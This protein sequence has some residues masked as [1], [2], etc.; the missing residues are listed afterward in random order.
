MGTVISKTI[1]YWGISSILAGLIIA[2]PMIVESRNVPKTI[3]H[4]GRS[5]ESLE[6]S[7]RAL[8]EANRQRLERDAQEARRDLQRSR[9]DY[10]RF[11]P[12]DLYPHGSDNYQ[13][14]RAEIEL[15]RSRQ[16][17][18]RAESDLYSYERRMESEARDRAIQQQRDRAG[19]SRD[20]Y[21]R[22]YPKIQYGR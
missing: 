7:Q 11:G 13:R 6:R 17:L 3:P 8:Q 15:N 16:D 14:Q 20:S 10:R 21:S 4:E 9:Q 1:K 12:G 5:Q 18:N 2:Y 19:S 22:S